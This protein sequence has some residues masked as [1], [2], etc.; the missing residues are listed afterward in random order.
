MDAMRENLDEKHVFRALKHSHSI[1]AFA[2]DA[3]KFFILL[4]IFE[5]CEILLAK[6]IKL[7]KKWWNR[8]FYDKLNKI[9]LLWRMLIENEKRPSYRRSY[10]F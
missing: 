8:S 2:I 1:T 9:V 10:R 3:A 6:F 5:G 7:V 4:L